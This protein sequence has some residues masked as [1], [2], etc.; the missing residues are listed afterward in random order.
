MRASCSVFIAVSLDG[1]IARSDGRIDWLS[2]V[3]EPGEDYGFKSFFDSIDTLVLGKNTY[4]VALGFQPWPY[5]GKRCVV[6]THGSAVPQHGAELYAGSPEALVDKL[7]A[8]GAQRVYVDGGKVIQQFLGAGLVTDL[9][10][11]V[12]PILLGDGVRLFGKLEADRR[13]EL[14]ES[15]PFKSG[16]VQLKYTARPPA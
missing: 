9:T 3:E 14:L 10:L 1:Y 5:H 2:I 12:L 16:L 8:E 11:S 15:R 6:L 4:E 7:T 13:L